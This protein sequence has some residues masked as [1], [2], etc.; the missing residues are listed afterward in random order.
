[1]AG[2][3]GA[4]HPSPRLRLRDPPGA[5]LVERDE[6]FERPLPARESGQRRGTL[7]DRAGGGRRCTL[8]PA[9]GG[10]SIREGSAGTGGKD[11]RMEAGAERDR[12]SWADRRPA[13]GDARINDRLRRHR[14]DPPIRGGG[15]YPRSCRSL[16]P[17][18]RG[19]WPSGDLGRQGGV[20]VLGWAAML[21]TGRRVPRSWGEGGWYWRSGSRTGSSEAARSAV[22]TAAGLDAAGRD[23]R[24]RGSRML[25]AEPARGLISDL[26]A[27]LEAFWASVHVTLVAAVAKRDDAVRLLTASVAELTSGTDYIN[28][29]DQRSV[30][31]A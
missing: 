18:A 9:R 25:W 6:A 22:L 20:V 2:R 12:F 3:L 16:A 5:V 1:M 26:P 24:V 15:G 10:G 31:S 7:P 27:T 8:W 21:G 13:G 11:H 29:L 28:S 17:V 4:V 19:Q 14:T 23:G 30:Q